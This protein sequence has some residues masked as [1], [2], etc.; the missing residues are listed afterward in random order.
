[1]PPTPRFA[2]NPNGGYMGI[3]MA[4]GDGGVTVVEVAPNSPAQEAGLRQGDLIIAIDDRA[5]KTNDDILEILREK[6]PGDLIR[7]LFI[8]DGKTQEVPLKLTKRPSDLNRGDFQNRMGSKLSDRRG[9]FHII[10]QHDSVLGPS[11]CGGPLVDLDGKV[12]GINIARAGRTETYAIPAEVVIPL[13]PEFK[14]GR[15]SVP[16]PRESSI[17]SRIQAIEE[18]IRQTKAELEQHRREREA[19]A[20]KEGSARKRLELLEAELKKLKEKKD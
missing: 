4:P 18:S 8:R 15:Y 19:L 11:D 5:V 14:A 10:L 9:G 3:V 13:I 17:E 16:K 20:Q 6:R 2:P 12:I 7:I 1:M